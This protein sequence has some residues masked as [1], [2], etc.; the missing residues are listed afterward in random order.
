MTILSVVTIVCIGLMAG[1]EFAVS[2][3]I[4]PVLWKLDA[5]TQARIVRMFARNLGAAMPFWYALSLLLL[6][7]ESILCRHHPGFALLVSASA[8]WTAAIV[9]T[10]LFLLPINNQ[11][12]R[13]ESSEWTEATRREHRKWDSRHRYRIAALVAAWV[14]SLLASLA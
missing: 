9:F 13:L 7:V 3:F 10:F 1:S 11:L 6:I 14:C 8:I 2:V 5:P 4:N 12:A